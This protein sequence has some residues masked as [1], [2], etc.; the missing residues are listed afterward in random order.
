MSNRKSKLVQS[1]E[2]SV[3]PIH[4]EDVVR[5]IAEQVRQPMIS[6]IELNLDYKQDLSILHLEDAFKFRDSM[7]NFHISP[8][9][10]SLD[11]VMPVKDEDLGDM[12]EAL[13]DVLLEDDDEGEDEEED[14]DDEEDNEDAEDGDRKTSAS[15]G[16]DQIIYDNN[17]GFY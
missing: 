5:F 1:L 11:E 4:H 16:N 6:P 10:E 7:K 2:E 9:A 3:S 12:L 8:T 17:L 13:T 14:D 15:S